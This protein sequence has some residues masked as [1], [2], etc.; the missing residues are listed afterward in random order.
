MFVCLKSFYIHFFCQGGNENM[1][2]QDNDDKNAMCVFVSEGTQSAF[3]DL[4]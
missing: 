1:L 4:N 2:T 3:E